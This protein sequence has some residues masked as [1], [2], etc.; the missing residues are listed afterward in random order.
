[1][2]A[3]RFAH[4][5]IFPVLINLID[6][7]PES[8][9]PFLADQFDVL[10]IKGYKYCV[11]E[12]D[13]RDLIKR[14]IELHRYKGTP[15]AVKQCLRVIGITD[16]SLLEGVSSITYNGVYNYDGAFTFGQ[17]QWARFRVIINAS[18]L[19][20]IDMDLYR[21]CIVL[22]NEYKNVRSHLVDISF[23]LLF[24][25]N[26]TIDVDADGFYYSGTALYDGTHNYDKVDLSTYIS[27][28]KFGENDT[29]PSVS[30]TDV[31][32]PFSKAIISVSYPSSG[33]V[34]Y[35]WSLELSEN[36]GVTIKEYA[37]YKSDG[38]LFVRVTGINV[39]KTNLI[40][41]E[42]SWTIYF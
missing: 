34:Q 24:T 26:K 6:M 16:V 41:L 18:A 28:I 35:N 15:Y 37:L 17:I 32:N 2:A 42:G 36:N 8:A 40:R 10:G 30:D 33:A 13:K 23:K 21:K 38:S 22:I 20:L 27:Y 1:M 39:V 7:V 14:A 12:D 19:S 29:P 9:L 25:S 11:T 4:I 5:D 3:A 31:T